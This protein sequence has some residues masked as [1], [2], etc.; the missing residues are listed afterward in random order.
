MNF[1][2]LIV[3]FWCLWYGER[4]KH[5]FFSPTYIFVLLY[6][7]FLFINS[8]E[9]S[10]YQIPWSPTSIALFAGAL[11]LF[12]V[13]V[14]IV[15][16]HCQLNHV[17]RIDFE[18]IR[19]SI[20]AETQNLDWKWFSRWIYTAGILFLLGFLEA[21]IQAKQLPA[22]SSNPEIARVKFVLETRFF[23]HAWL[24]GP[25]TLMLSFEFLLLSGLPIR[26][27]LPVAVFSLTVLLAYLTIVTR[28]DLFR[29]F[30]FALLLFHYSKQ[31]VS[32]RGMFL[33]GTLALALFFAFYLI[34]A[35]NAMSLLV[36]YRT[37]K[38]HVARGF[39]WITI[40]YSYVVNNFWNFDYA[41]RHYYEGVEYYPYGYG[42]QT[43]KPLLQVLSLDYPLAKSYGFDN[44][45]NQS[46]VV[47]KGFNTVIFP[48]PLF[49]DLGPFSLYFFSFVFGI[50]TAYFYYNTVL[51][52]PTLSRIGTW[53]IIAGMI[54]F[55]CITDFWAMW[56][57]YM[58]IAL[59]WIAHRNR[60][61]AGG[62]IV[63]L[64][65]LST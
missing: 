23:V 38:I 41:I 15:K 52:R 30:I 9:L 1:L 6:S 43:F 26:R 48:W 10:R 47:A 37:S 45:F 57:P 31:R 40:I 39:E 63:T 50:L 51:R 54:F 32:A 27:K 22:F 44:V 49:K 4:K 7:L 14:L 5:D 58:N 2:Y 8:F 62:P 42:Y 21:Y 3:F 60:K 13:A 35:Q 17:E 64:E 53:G 19:N 33:F 24:F 11:G 59:I 65:P 46:L 20:A 18:I 61:P 25:P 28:V 56:F 12:L 29:F 16:L 34:R 55:S 36:S